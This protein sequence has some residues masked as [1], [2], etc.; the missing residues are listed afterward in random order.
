M[1]QVVDQIVLG[2]GSTFRVSCQTVKETDGCRRGRWSDY[3]G[4]GG[5]FDVVLVVFECV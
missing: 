1:G 2:D 4:D 5:R 3:R